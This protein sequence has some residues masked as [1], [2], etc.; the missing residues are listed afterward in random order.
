M[1]SSSHSARYPVRR[2]WLVLFLVVAAASIAAWHAVAEPDP[3]K[4]PLAALKQ[5]AGDVHYTKLVVL[6]DKVQ[7][8]IYDPSLQYSPDGKIGYLAY[9][10]ITGDFKPVGP[11]V[12]THLARSDDHGRSWHFVKAVCPSVDGLLQRPGSDPLAGV[13]R[14]EVPSLCCDPTDRGREWKLF[15]HKYFWNAKKN[16][17]FDYGWIVLRTAGDPAGTWSEEVPLFG[18]GQVVLFGMLKAGRFPRDPYHQTRVD[19]NQLDPSL[20]GAVAYSEPG[21]I[22]RDGTIYLSLSVMGPGGPER[23]VLL[24]SSD[25]AA[26]WRFVNTL[27]NGKDAQALGYSYLDGSSLAADRGR[28]FLLAVPGSRRQMHDGT[29]ALEFES[30][31]LGRLKRNPDG[32]LRVAAYFAPQPSILSGPGAGQSDYDERNTEGGLLMPQF[33]VRA[34]PEVFQIYQTGRRIV[35]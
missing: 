34:Y 24:A 10:S 17:M 11:Y 13:W 18:S 25:H 31:A 3:A 23:I 1:M 9:S 27:V 19:L 7:G 12:H 33:N 32:S 22:V 6:G 16:R 14:Y 4:G 15:V 8:G 35:P 2:R 26:T 28:V 5:Q 29:V 20:A 21:T 30:L